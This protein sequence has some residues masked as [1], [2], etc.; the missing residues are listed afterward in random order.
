MNARFRIGKKYRFKMVT[1]NFYISQRTLIYD[2]CFRVGFGKYYKFLTPDGFSQH[3]HAS[4]IENGDVTVNSEWD[5]ES[6]VF[7]AS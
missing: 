1:D 7:Y 4:W 6:E 2:G 3:C 5:K